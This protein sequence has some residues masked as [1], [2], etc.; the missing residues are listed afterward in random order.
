MSLSEKQWFVMRDLKRRTSNSLAVHDLAKAGF[1]V[2]TPMTQMVMKIG[3][4]LQRR[5]VPVIQDLLFVHESKEILDP[6]VELM[7]TLQYRYQRG[8]SKDE[9]TTVRNE[10]MEKFIFAVS[11]TETPIYYKPGELTPAMYGKSVLICGGRLD[12]YEGRLLSV[13]GMRKRRLIVELSG[14]MAAAVE[15]EP[16]YIHFV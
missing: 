1:E 5:D 10:E 4:K 16:D 6:F 3:G 13:K 15:V 7:P 2:F 9:P 14:F 12:G 11:K 8:K